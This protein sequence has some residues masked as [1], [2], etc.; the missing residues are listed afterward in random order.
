MKKFLQKILIWG[1]SLIGL[2]IVLGFYADGNT[3]DNYRH[4]IKRSSN[5]ILGDSRGSQAIVSSI[6]SNNFPANEFDN[7]ALNIVD[8]PYGEIYFNAIK[9]KLD[10]SVKD[11]IFFLT[12]DPW[13]LS[14]NKNI[15][16]FRN[17]PENRSPLK[18]VFFYNLNPNFEY[19]IKNYKQSWFLLYRDREEQGKSN[20]YLHQ[21]GWLEVTVDMNHIEVSKRLKE[22]I[23]FYND[24]LKTQ[25]LS[26]YRI[27][28]FEKIIQ[29]LQQYG[30]V[31]IIRI[32][33]SSEMTKIE[34]KYCPKFNQIVL[35]IS[36]KHQVNYFDFS[37]QFSKFQYTD[38]N[39][40]YKESSKIF[41]QRIADSIKTVHP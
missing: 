33:V 1:V 17:Y 6:L 26:S 7:F 11:G 2:F 21:D 24:L 29:Y 38:G 14:I 35:D 4:F 23:K 34:Q 32:P 30:K 36:K 27:A 3:D 39:H 19:L 22:K 18:N 12:V 40:M 15:D 9:R 28:Y 41:T 25:E 10:T 13:N 5:L 16:N 37:L 8:S 31:Y 20:T